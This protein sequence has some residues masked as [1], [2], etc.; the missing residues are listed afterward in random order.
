ML[1]SFGPAVNLYQTLFPV[2]GAPQVAF[3][4]ASTPSVVAPVV[5]SSAWYGNAETVAALPILSLAGAG[6][7]PWIE[8]CNVPPEPV[9]SKTRMRYVLPDVIARL[10]ETGPHAWV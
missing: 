10:T 2:A 9:S 8:R 7:G 5:S 6:A 4:C 1:W 3:A